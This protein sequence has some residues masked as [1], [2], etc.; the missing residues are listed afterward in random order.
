MVRKA[1]EETLA[2]IH[3]F[4]GK[5]P[6]RISL[7][8]EGKKILRVMCSEENRVSLRNGRLTVEVKAPFEAIAVHLA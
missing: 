7:P 2:V 6:E 8:A 1:G 5:L 4:G 3:T